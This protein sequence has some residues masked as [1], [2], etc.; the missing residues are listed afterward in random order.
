TNKGLDR[1]NIHIPYYNYRSAEHIK[2]LTAQTYNLDASGNMITSKV[3]KK[4]I[5]DKKIN[6]RH[7]EQ[8]FT[9]PEVKSGSIIEYKYSVEASGFRGLLDWYFQKSIPVK[10]SQYT[11]NFPPE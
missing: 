6:S 9:F 4:L 2:N 5:Y 10:F 8:V 3:E 1:A 7:S 11:I